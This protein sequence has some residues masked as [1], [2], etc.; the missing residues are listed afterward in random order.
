MPRIAPSADEGVAISYRK[1]N[2]FGMIEFFNTGEIVAV[3][4]EG[5]SRP[6]V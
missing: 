3:T 1:E 5:T 2:R 6:V 4:S